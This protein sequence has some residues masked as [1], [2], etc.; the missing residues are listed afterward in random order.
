[1][2]NRINALF[3]KS[4]LYQNGFPCIEDGHDKH[5]LKT[6]KYLLDKSEILNGQPGT[7]LDWKSI[8][9]V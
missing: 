8:F 3:T 5:A 9:G 4:D 2:S 7:V 1:M 6:G